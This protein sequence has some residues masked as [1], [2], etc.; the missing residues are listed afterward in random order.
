MAR[1]DP[2]VLRLKIL[3][4]VVGLSPTVWLGWN[5]AT[6][7]LGA[8]PIEKALHVTGRWA[9]VL[10]LASLAITPI[11]RFS[12]WN[13]VIQL[14]RP[15][16]LFAFYYAVVHFAIYVGL[17]QFF[18]FSFILEDVT[19][20]PFIT[21]GFGA[22]I[23]LTPLAATSTRGWIRR[24]GRRWQVLHRLVYAA[25][26]LAVVHFYWKVKADTFWPVVA[27]GILA[28]LLAARLR[29]S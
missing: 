23:L 19:E 27:A 22:L 1:L 28:L 13:R 5:A 11:R 3:V 4:W 8:N 12:G 9:L 21:T 25:G 17:D 14:R 16:G 20:R 15:V 29:R 7:G 24:L 26:L 2:T 6:G 18:A 10:L